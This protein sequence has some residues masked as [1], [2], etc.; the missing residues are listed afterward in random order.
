LPASYRPVRPLLPRWLPARG[1]HSEPSDEQT[2]TKS[3]EDRYIEPSP[4]RR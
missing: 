1:W 4:P 3:G 2:D